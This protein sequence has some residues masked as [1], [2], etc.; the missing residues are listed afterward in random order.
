MQRSSKVS[1]V[2]DDTETWNDDDIMQ[3]EE[4]EEEQAD[5]IKYEIAHYP[6]DY[7]LSAY[8]DRWN[9]GQLV[10]PKFQ[11]SFVW[12][13]VQA[14]RLI[15]SFLLGLP[16]PPVF[17]YKERRTNRLLVL[18]GQQRIF[19]VIR[20]FKNEF[21]ERI[22][23]LKGVGEEW[24]GRVFEELDE[25][26]RFRLTDSVLRAIVV[27]QVDPRDDTSVFQIFER[28]NTG[29]VNLNAMEVRKCVYAGGFYDLLEELN[30]LEEWRRLIGKPKSDRRLRDVEFILRILAF[31]A[32]L[33]EYE[34][35]MKQFL[36]YCMIEVNK[37]S[38]GRR[39]KHLS[40][41]EM[42]FAQAC[43]YLIEEV[44]EKPFHL[45]GRLNYAVL[46]SIMYCVF[47]AAERKLARFRSRY[48]NLLQDQDYINAVT[49]NTS[50]EKIVRQRFS[51]AR[52]YL[53]NDG[54]IADADES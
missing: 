29:G 13:Q 10:I 52:T 35:P 2:I 43:A 34:K 32:R 37:M 18:D 30:K 26:D 28:L 42:L 31:H 4:A 8:L 14:S 51:I 11:R 5:V 50:D 53:L 15:E 20:F 54:E 7:P 25:S 9:S 38:A 23:R 45:R 19:S 40:E 21:D 49:Y 6:A 1:R 47:R 12:G 48:D 24:E 33:D 27:Q 36:N 46:D 17:L 3:T 22:F 41:I 39:K 44:G 16:V